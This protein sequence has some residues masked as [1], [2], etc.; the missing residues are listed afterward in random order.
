VTAAA[1]VRAS[2]A[3]NLTRYARSWGLWFLLLAGPVGARFMVA[4]DD[5]SGIQIAVGRHLPVI[6]SPVLGVSLGVVVS[7]LLLPIGFLYLRSNVT[8]RQPWQV[9][10]VTAAPR[11]AIAFGRFGADVA[12]LFAMLATLTVAGW[13][14]GWLIVS[15][16]LDIVQVTWPLW[17][18]AAPS[19]VGLAAV[20]RLLDALPVTR[21]GLGDAVFFVLW[22]A[23]LVVPVA[24][25]DQPSSL[26]TNL[27]D[28]A[29]FVRP[30]AGPVP[31]RGQ[32]VLIGGGAGLLP[33]RVPLDVMAG[34]AAPGYLGSRLVW[35]V[36]G[37]AIAMLAG[38][39]YR[40]HTQPRRR[41]LGGAV[42]RLLSAGAPPAVIADAPPAQSIAI[43]FVGL[44]VG[45]FRLI[46]AGRL[47][48]LL[49]L[50]AAFAGLSGDYR[51][52]GSPAAVL[53]L[54]FGLVAHAGRSE[55]S[56]LLSLTRTM[57]VPPWTRRVAFVVA[58]SGWALL[59]ALPAALVRASPEPL[60]LT[61]AV[62]TGAAVVAMALASWSHSAFAARLVLLVAWYV[63][64]SS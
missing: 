57:V 47:F 4:R 14:L 17:V 21:R 9:E 3:T 18:I 32:D 2:F 31:L 63:Y 8:R 22:L 16:P 49:A 43:P 33:G 54:V 10:E 35:V 41:R 23:S 59:L 11:I 24:V 53:L 29:G 27:Y 55:A 7:V 51:H 58:G 50:L 37:V 38:L 61:V 52:I 36:L 30:L 28:F 19:L 39:L 13:F 45:E 6:T 42:A 12:I 48:T 62:G 34:I 56:G 25:A 15:G 26:S 64:L 44:V 1:V 40:P 20:H 46:G 5:G 60:V